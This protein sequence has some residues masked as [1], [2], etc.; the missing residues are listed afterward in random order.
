MNDALT[1]E[2]HT[3]DVHKLLKE[4]VKIIHCHLRGMEKD[5]LVRARRALK[6]PTHKAIDK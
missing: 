6:Q 1:K 5:W 3:E 2:T 4:A